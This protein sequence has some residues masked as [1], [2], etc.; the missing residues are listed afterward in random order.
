MLITGHTDNQPIRTAALS[1]QLA[2]VAGRAPTRSQTMLGEAAVEPERMR[3]EGRA[4]AEPVADNAR[5]P[6]ARG[7][8][9]SRSRL[10]VASCEHAA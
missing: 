8:G 4:D 5:P 2:P 7:T 10:F 6:A 1:V 3:A 9:A